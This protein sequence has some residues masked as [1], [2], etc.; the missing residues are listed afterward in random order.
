M[1]RQ[2]VHLKPGMVSQ[3]SPNNTNSNSNP[4]L[5]AID[6]DEATFS[7]AYCNDTMPDTLPWFRIELGRQ[8]GIDEVSIKLRYGTYGILQVI[9]MDGRE[10]YN[11]GTS[12]DYRTQY[13]VTC[14]GVIGDAVYVMFNLTNLYC[15]DLE[16]REIKVFEIF[17]AGKVLVTA[18]NVKIAPRFVK[19]FIR[20]TKH[21]PM[22]EFN[23]H[24][25]G[26]SR[27]FLILFLKLCIPML[28]I[29]VDCEPGY[30]RNVNMAQCDQCMANSY[31]AA[32]ATDCTECKP[33][34][35]SSEGAN[36]CVECDD[37]TE[38][39]ADR[40]GCSKSLLIL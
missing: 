24:D 1:K 22:G 16:I 19:S 26:R 11:C 25:A 20:F 34:T 2:E 3:T 17:R 21:K 31:S 9:V 7:R 5:M 32:G 4:A 12:F 28:F 6:N 29:L 15:V 38:V 23:N 36:I 39:N 35:Y 30:Y 18:Y 40:T 33:N 27:H 13:L 14:N 8:H 10:E 37:G